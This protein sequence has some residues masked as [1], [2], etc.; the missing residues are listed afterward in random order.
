MLKGDNTAQV[1]SDNRSLQS[2]YNSSA[3][4]ASSADT[5]LP[6]YNLIT[7]ENVKQWQAERRSAESTTEAA[8][9]ALELP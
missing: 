2:S 1:A 9:D 4:L 6:R 3:S 8:E 5:P 7:R